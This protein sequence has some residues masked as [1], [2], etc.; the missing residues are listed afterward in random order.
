MV[1][2]W[3]QSMTKQDD[4]DVCEAKR[5][6]RTAWMWTDISTKQTLI[7]LLIYNFLNVCFKL[8]GGI[9]VLHSNTKL[10]DKYSPNLWEMR[11]SLVSHQDSLCDLLICNVVVK[12]DISNVKNSNILLLWTWNY[13]LTVLTVYWIDWNITKFPTELL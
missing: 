11:P 4:S 2:S 13:V 3:W 12:F 5:E 9:A 10:W 6:R 1:V 7:L 8:Q